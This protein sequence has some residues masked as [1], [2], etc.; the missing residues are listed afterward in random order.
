DAIGRKRGESN[1]AHGEEMALN[2][3][4]TEMDG[5]SVDPRRP[6]FVM[7]A[8]NFDVEEGK[9]G[10]GEIDPALARR[11]DRRVLV[12]LP[13]AEEREQLLHLLLKK[14]PDHEVTDGMIRRTAERA[15]GLSLAALTGIVEAA[16]RMASKAGKPMDDAMLDEAYEVAR[17]GAKKDWGYEYLERVARHESGHAFLCYLGGNT[18]AYL[19]IVARGDH[20]GY[21]EHSQKDM[22]PLSTREEMIH[23]I[24][25]SLGGRAAEIAY[26]GEEAGIST[27]A[28]G[29]LEQATRT[30]AAML[31]AYGMDEGF[32]LASMDL[33]DALKDPAVRQKINEILRGEMAATVELIRKNKPRIDRMV[34]ALMKQN[35][36]SSEEMEA[37]LKED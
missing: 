30:A 20:G 29:D 2:A 22:G 18:P 35:K 23:R 21:M 19:T 32:G 17:H 1:T 14:H 16:N 24:R 15:A 3:L 8:T 9:G 37:L 28:S 5:F 36:L 25:T 11:F 34:D 13:N 27:G 31:C 26:Y 10:L 6:V 12:D 7:A 4:L 33:R